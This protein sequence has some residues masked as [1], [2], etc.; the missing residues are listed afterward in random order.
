MHLFNFQDVLVSNH[1]RCKLS[2]CSFHSMCTKISLRH[3]LSE[4]CQLQG[5]E[6]DGLEIN[7]VFFCGWVKENALVVLSACRQ[8]FP[9]MAKL[10]IWQTFATVENKEWFSSRGEQEVLENAHFIAFLFICFWFNGEMGIYFER[11]K[12]N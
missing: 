2:V 11:K 3:V 4:R 5:D 12:V 10:R 1:P 9:W 7:W 8:R 6:C